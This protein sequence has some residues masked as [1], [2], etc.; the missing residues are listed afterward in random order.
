[1]SKGAPDHEAVKEQVAER[2]KAMGYSVEKE[3][4]TDSRLRVDVA[5]FSD[6]ENVAVEVG[7]LNGEN[8]IERLKTDGFDIVKHIPLGGR[9]D[10]RETSWSS[11]RREVSAEI[12]EQL[13]KKFNRI[14]E[15][16]EEHSPS[17][18]SS[19]EAVRVAIRL[20]DQRLDELWKQS[21]DLSQEIVMEKGRIH[22]ELGKAIDSPYLPRDIEKTEDFLNPMKPEDRG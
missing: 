4:R 20:A 11:E 7:A 21:M 12:D 16:T 18:Y 22:R 5:A 19:T 3:Y 6:D 10:V 8:R 1:M 17:K 14:E 15:F 9:P 2:Y 13:Q